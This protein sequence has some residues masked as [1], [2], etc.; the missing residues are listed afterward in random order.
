MS[1]DPP[2]AHFL[3]SLILFSPWGSGY[4]AG[5]INSA[6]TIILGRNGMKIIF[7]I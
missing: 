7:G 6:G 1:S 2:S 3:L 4:A 5:V